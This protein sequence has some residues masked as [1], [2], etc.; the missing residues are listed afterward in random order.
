MKKALIFTLVLALLLSL[1]LAGCGSD[2]AT[3]PTDADGTTTQ[4]ATTT[5]A[6]DD[7][8]ETTAEETSEETDAPVIVEYKQAP[9]LAEMDLPPV[10]ERLPL[11]PKLTNEI[12][13]KHLEGGQLEIGKYGG[14]LR[15]ANN[16]PD[17]NP[18][19]FLLNNEP[20]LNTPGAIGEEVTP[21]IVKAFEMSDDSMEFTFYMREGLKWSDGEPVTTEDVQFAVEDVLMNEVLSPAGIP[22]WLRAANKIDGDPMEFQVIDDYTFKISFTEAYGRFPIQVALTGWRGYTDL[23]KPKHFL[24]D[25]H[26][27]YTPL[28]DLEAEIEAEGFEEGQ[29]NNLFNLRDITNWEL[30]NRAAAGFPVLYPYVMKE[31]DDESMQFVR[32]PYYYKVDAAG[33]QLPYIDEIRSDLVADVEMMAVKVVAGEIDLMRESASLSKIEIY[34]ENEAAGNFTAVLLNMHVNPTCMFINQTFDDANWRSVVRDV[35]FRQALNMALDRDEII[36]AVYYGL[37]SLPELVPSEYDKEGAMAL[38]DEM[39]MEVGPDGFRV[40]PDGK[41][42]ELPMFSNP[43][44]PDMI[45]VNELVAEMWTDIGIKVAMTGI[46]GS[47]WGQRIAANEA[48]VINIWNVEPMW[49]SGGWTDFTTGNN[50]AP[51]WNLWR[52]SGGEQGEEPPTEIKRLYELGVLINTVYPGTP[53]D[54]AYYDEI[55]QIHYDYIYQMPIAEKVKQP[56]IINSNIG[57]VAID[58]TAVAVNIGG[59]QL[60]YRDG[61]EGQ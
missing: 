43:I 24:T 48:Q 52:T 44:A 14:I 37:G 57:N 31:G 5:A 54:I 25:Y 19:I 34:K 38:L 1:G 11:E 9:M 16:G 33:N 21:N 35:R 42:F 40:G 58:G 3:D 28:E 10:S 22:T 50:E 46:E 7:T 32:N 61:E 59:E 15:M 56:L 17:W 13:A 2:T 29:W 41:T 26:I 55:W 23:I 27:E 8:D 51:L 18:D 12:P 36:D 49:R 39:G 47:L 53:E 6:P 45:P 60:F 30:T 4:E 20:L